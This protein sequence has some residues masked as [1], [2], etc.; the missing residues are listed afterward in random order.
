MMATG[1]L[2]GTSMPAVLIPPAATLTSRHSPCHD[3]ARREPTLASVWQAVA[4]SMIS[5][6]LL[7]WPPDLFTLTE[8]ILQRSQAYRFALSPP[9]GRTWPP[10]GFPDWPDAVIDAARRWSTW[11]EDRTGSLPDLLVREW[12]VVRA[13]AGIPFSQLGEA[14][15]WQLC[16]ALL[17][18]HAIA[19]EACAGLGV[20]LDATGAE[21]LVYRA[22]GREL[23]ARTGS[24][25]RLPTHLIRA[26]PKVAT[27]LAGSS[28]RALSRYAAVQEPDVEVRWHRTPARGPAV[29]PLGKKVNYLLLPWPLKV[30]Q[31]EFHPV[32]GPLRKLAGDPFGF[33]EF[34]PSEPL[35]LDLVDRML[36]AAR[37]QAGSVDV[38]ILPESAVEHG[39][40]D[41]LE[42][43]LGRHGATGLITG[44]REHP[45]KPGQ[46]PGNWLHIGV[47]AA[48]Q[49][50]HIRQPK[51][52]RWSLDDAQIR[53][54]HL[55]DAL[56]PHIRWWEAMEVPGRSLQFVELCDGV[57]LASLV[58]EDLAQTDEVAGVIRSVGPML[59]VIP[60]LDGPQLSSRW[61]ARYASIL[62]D[63]PGSAVLTLT[64]FGMAHRSWLPGQNPSPVVALW[65]NPGQRPCEIPLRPG[66]QGILLSAAVSRAT[67]RSFDGRRP[68]QNGSEF[69]DVTIHQVQA[70]STGTRS[71]Q[72]LAGSPSW[73]TLAVDELTI[74][75]SWV[76]ATAEALAF[77]PER[78]EAITADA[79]AGADW[80]AELRICEPSRTLSEAI[81]DVSRVARTAA[82][83]GG[84]P[85]LQ[86][87]HVAVCQ[88]QPGPPAHERLAH[89]MLRSALEQC[90]AR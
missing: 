57:T 68:A 46:F 75:T 15:D 19:D 73:R 25:A 12:G 3:D 60:L 1:S 36:V 45:P 63:D 48:E 59:V 84:D 35:D 24:L 31:S 81:N 18:L 21:G 65:N 66:A 53:Q 62:A 5:D 55:A 28:V 90:Q 54:Y 34:T 26:L 17:T 23:L 9:A 67:R 14:R 29:Q 85:P 27:P 4:G 72:S 7:E 10:A 78:V 80:R 39:E 69:S 50:V 42:A 79:Q 33:F 11:A 51:H 49:W 83:A 20:A 87:C 70:A 89:A 56:D 76:Q 37:K 8:V 22:R 86:A 74:L 30:R 52:H 44:V 2:D 77:A 64:S 41:D 61:G 82:A 43:L 71:P 38:V 47:S 40:V 58:C 32:P 6:T 13:R 88:G 16:A